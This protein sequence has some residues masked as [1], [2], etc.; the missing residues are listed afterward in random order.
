MAQ[1]PTSQPFE[2]PMFREIHKNTWLKKISPSSPKKKREK[3]WVVF[4]IHDDTDAYLETYT[5]NKLAVFHKPDWFVCLNNI[6]HISPTICA[7][8]QEYEFVLTLTTEVIRLAAPSW[9]QMLDWV[10]GLK[11]KLFE[12][13]ILSP[14]ENV[15]TKLPDK[16]NLPLLPTRDPTSPLPPPPESPPEVLPG[17][18]SEVTSQRER[19]NLIS[20]E[21]QRS[22]SQ[23]SIMPR[24]MDSVNEPQ[25]AGASWHHVFNFDQLNYVLGAANSLSSSNVHYEHLFQIQPGP[26]NRNDEFRQPIREPSVSNRIL[27]RS[28]SCSPRILQ[29][30]P[31]PYKTLREQQVLMLEKEMKHPT[32]VRVQL[33]KKD[34]ISS[35]GFVDAFNAVWIC[36]WK[37]KEHPMLYNAL[38]IGDRLLNIEGITVKSAADA[39][40]ILQSHYCGLYVNIVIKRVPYGRVFV[41]HKETEGQPLGIV[42][43][44]NTAIIETVQTNSLAARHG[45]TAKTKSCDGTS[46]TNW[47]LTEINGRPLNL[48]FKKN[49]VRDRLNSVGRDISILVQPLDLIKQLKKQMKSLKNYKDYILQ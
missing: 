37:Q 49:Q 47:V 21:R 35:I 23:S 3:L 28:A 11:T 46:F 43:E 16:P 25:S 6:Q 13:R 31:R 41:I 33:R 17:I 18:E 8:D 32:G 12:L 34:C 4:C 1:Q 9:E 22:E 44:N 39:Q 2:N 30:A 48:F 45:L 38:H 36:G 42:Q 29:S 10:E 15:Y 24:R 19:V 40:K 27:E 26:S 14:K 7:Q 20:Y 5:D